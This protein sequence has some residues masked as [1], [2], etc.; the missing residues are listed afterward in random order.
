MAAAKR[1]FQLKPAGTEPDVVLIVAQIAE[2][3]SESADAALALAADAMGPAGLDLL[4]RLMLTRSALAP[5]IRERLA[6]DSARQRMSEALA[7]AFDLRVASSCADRVPL[8]PRAAEVGDERSFGALAAVSTGAPRGCGRN[9][10]K[11]CSPA[12]PQEAAA[13][14]KTM[15]A[16]SRRMQSANKAP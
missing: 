6:K 4:F 8:L 3:R 13:F 7:I 2:S 14:R 5:R 12:C 10:R 1:L 15:D 16:I 9:K 11:P